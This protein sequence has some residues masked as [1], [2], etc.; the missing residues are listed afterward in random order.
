MVTALILVLGWWG[1]IPLGPA[2]G[3]ALLWQEPI[4]ALPV[5]VVAAGKVLFAQRRELYSEQLAG[6]LRTTAAELRAGMSLRSS[7]V[8]AATVY[9]GLGL[10]QMARLAAAGRPMSEVSAALARVPGMEA[11]SVVLEV[12]GVTGGSVAPVLEALAAESADEAGL[13]AERRSLTVAA[14]WSI[15]LVGGFP[16]LVLAVQIARGEIGRM[17]NGG[18]VSAALVVVGIGLLLSGMGIAG[19]LMRKARA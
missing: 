18:I 15:G 19:F 11:A 9:S 1:T 7:L 14:R 8:A 5:L 6:W 2:L 16:L 3:L 17:L 10:G 4:A 12:T 13:T